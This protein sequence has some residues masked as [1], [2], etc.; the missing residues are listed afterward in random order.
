MKNVASVS[1]SMPGVKILRD[2]VLNKRTALTRAERNVLGLRGDPL[3]LGLPQNR[4][5]GRDYD[6]FDDEFVEANPMKCSLWKCKGSD[7]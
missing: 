7:Q 5:R 1:R 4:L 6:A 2:L 3:Y